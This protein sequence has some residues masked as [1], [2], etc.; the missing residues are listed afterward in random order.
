MTPRNLGVRDSW[1]EM[2]REQDRKGWE[3]DSSKAPDLL[4]VSLKAVE[5]LI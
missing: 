2:D 1:I 5:A 4:T 3:T